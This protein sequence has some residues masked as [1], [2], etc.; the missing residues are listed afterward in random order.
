MQAVPDLAKYV[1]S[2]DPPLLQ[3]EKIQEVGKLLGTTASY[4]FVYLQG[5]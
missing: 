3:G 1:K 4:M 5:W 2:D